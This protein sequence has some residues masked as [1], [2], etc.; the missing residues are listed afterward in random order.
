MQA[1]HSVEDGPP[2]ARIGQDRSERTF[3][4]Y[5]HENNDIFGAGEDA[6]GSGL[7]LWQEGLEELLWWSRG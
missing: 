7:H 4:T 3:H 2:P 6:K 5:G 1:L